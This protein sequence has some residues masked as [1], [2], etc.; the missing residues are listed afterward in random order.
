MEI[1]EDSAATVVGASTR[2]PEFTPDVAGQYTVKVTDTTDITKQDPVELRIFA[3]KGSLEICAEQP[4]QIVARTFNLGPGG[5]VGQFYDGHVGG[6]G[7]AVSQ[8]GR[9]LGLRQMT[10]SFRT[11]ISVTNTGM[12]AAEVRITLYAADGTVLHAYVLTVGPGRVVQD[13]QPF[14]RRAGTADLGWAM[15]LCVIVPSA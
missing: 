2:A 1:P 12:E 11:N 5:T 8:S 15:R 6:A 3:G 14:K 4:M 13:S 10:A 9:L 7:L